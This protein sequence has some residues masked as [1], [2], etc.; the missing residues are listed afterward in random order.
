MSN[1]LKSPD[2]K[3]VW[4]A[5]NAVNGLSISTPPLLANNSAI[6]RSIVGQGRSNPASSPLEWRRQC[7]LGR[8]LIA[9]ERFFEPQGRLFLPALFAFTPERPERPSNR[10][11]S[12]LE[13]SSSRRREP[14]VVQFNQEGEGEKSLGNISKWIELSPSGSEQ[15]WFIYVQLELEIGFLYIYFF[16]FL[17]NNQLGSS[18]LNIEASKYF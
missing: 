1:K 17:L 10:R 4:I 15:V 16:F 5:I 6:N 8:L 18:V 12:K 7:R 14:R 2:G 13:A 3:L 11:L 9:T